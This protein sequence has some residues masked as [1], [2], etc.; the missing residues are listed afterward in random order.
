MHGSFFELIGVGGLALILSHNLFKGFHC[1]CWFIKQYRL[2]ILQNI[3]PLLS[4]QRL[5]R[6]VKVEAKAEPFNLRFRNLFWLVLP[7]GK[8]QQNN[9]PP[10][11][12]LQ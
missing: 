4:F 10:C 2:Y 9:L 6:M 5:I 12:Q 7:L 3:A 11:F 1:K 8:C